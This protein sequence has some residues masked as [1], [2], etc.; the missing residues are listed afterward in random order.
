MRLGILGGSFD[1]IH[2]GHLALGE[3]A[4]DQLALDKVLFMPA[5]DQW[6]K[7]GR[8][9]APSGDRLAMA[10]LA[11]GRNPKFKVSA[12]EIEREG[13]T[14]TIDTLEALGSESPGVEI[15]FI[16]G[17]DALADM[18]NWREPERIF[19][20]ATVCV[21]ARAGE[22]VTD[23]R[24]TRIEMPEVDV[25]SS[26]VRERVKKGRSVGDLVPT[27]VERYIDEQKLYR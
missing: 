16:V 26:G 4:L 24:V 6:R 11:V 23:G 3:A 20:M 9:V 10:R 12:M 1:P 14:Y 27:V 18:P 8:D 5:G 15:F 25:S 13:P 19:E 22:A 2:I 17:A 7:A 21:A